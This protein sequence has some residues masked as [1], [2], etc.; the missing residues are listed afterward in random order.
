MATPTRLIRPPGN[1]A[2][3]GVPGVT[4]H[5]QIHRYAAELTALSAHDG[6]PPV[7]FSANNYPP[8]PLRLFWYS[9]QIF[10]Q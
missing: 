5:I 1:Q 7:M 6:F 10:H 9:L 2:G 3:E 8:E 4:P